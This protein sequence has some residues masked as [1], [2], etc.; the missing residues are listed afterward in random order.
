MNPL[1]WKGFKFWLGFLLVS[2]MVLPL[3]GCRPPR[4]VPIG[5]IVPLT[6]EYEEMGTAMVQAAEMAVAEFNASDL[7]IDGE[8]IKLILHVEDDAG[9]PEQSVGAAL[10]LINQKRVD[11]IV[12][13]PLDQTAIA[14]A[15]IAEDHKIPMISPTSTNPDT[16]EGRR[17]V[18]RATFT[19]IFQAQAIAQ[20]ALETLTFDKRVVVLYDV[21]NDYNRDLA[22][23]F[24]ETYEAAGGRILA[25]ESYVTGD[26]D[27]TDE[28]ERIKEAGGTH[29][30]VLFL[31]NYPHD[32]SLQVQQ[33]RANGIFQT[34]LGADALGGVDP[35]DY[36]EFDR[37]FLTAVWYPEAQDERSVAFVA[38]YEAAHG[39]KPTSAAALTYDSIGLIVHAMRARDKTDS[40]SIR[41]GLAYTDN[42]EGVTG[43]TRYYGSG[44]PVKGVAFLQIKGGR[45]YFYDLIYPE[46][47]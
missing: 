37:T 18:F 26:Q 36:P 46:T 35:A 32:V 31:P 6:G 44:D 27:F 20:F 8:R 47:P 21:A 12:G 10:R 16:T 7:E 33:A 17:Y 45:F 5:L 23:T 42:Y 43:P 39:C 1:S 40:E 34:I 4:E 13:P 9:N 28:Y 14:V 24:K 22:E 3:L 41:V 2:G 25:F 29:M 38:A 15:N 19:N 11:V 30:E